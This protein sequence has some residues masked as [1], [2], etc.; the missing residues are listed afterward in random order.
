MLAG[1]PQRLQSGAV[2]LRVPAAPVRHVGTAL[3]CAFRSWPPGREPAPQGIGKG[4]LRLRV[5]RIGGR[6]TR[7]YQ[8]VRIAG[9]SVTG[10][11]SP[12]SRTGQWEASKGL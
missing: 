5:R 10:P 7:C 11:S 6:N 1:D 9:R 12:D 3:E 4:I 2:R 8:V